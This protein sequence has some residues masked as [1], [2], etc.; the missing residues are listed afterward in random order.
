MPTPTGFGFGVTPSKP[1]SEAYMTPE[2]Q[3]AGQGQTAASDRGLLGKDALDQLTL[4]AYSR[5]E[6]SQAAEQRRYEEQMGA[7]RALIGQA[8]QRF[9]PSRAAQEAAV[10]A[11]GQRAAGLEGS[12]AAQ[13]V[14]AQREAAI[15]QASPQAILGGQIGAAQAR[16]MQ[17]LEQ[18]AA[19]RQAAYTR[20]V[21][22]LGAGLMGEAEQRRA[23]EAEALRDLQVRYAAAQ[24]FAGGERERRSQQQQGL[25]G[26]LAAFGGSLLGSAAGRSGG[27][28]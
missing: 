25:F 14:Q 18:E 20:G 10:V 27:K 8:D 26:G 9:A 28:K 4:G 6:A 16:S 21:Q 17:G 7:L 5:Q 3:T 22:Q 2:E 19:Q 1:A 12:A 13:A 23:A 11:L 24:A 15:M